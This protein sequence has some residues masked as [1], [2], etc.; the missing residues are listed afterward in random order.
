MYCL[1]V[2]CDV[3]TYATQANC[4]ISKREM[5]AVGPV[6]SLALR[7]AALPAALLTLFLVVLLLQYTLSIAYHQLH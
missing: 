1:S 4:T 7:E 6:D 2:L 5:V 3:Q